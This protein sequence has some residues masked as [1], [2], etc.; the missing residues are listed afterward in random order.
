MPVFRRA[1]WSRRPR[2]SIASKVKARAAIDGVQQT[3][4]RG[5][6]QT[7]GQLLLPIDA[8]GVDLAIEARTDQAAG[9]QEA[10]EAAQLGDRV[11]ERSAAQSLPDATDERF[12][13]RRGER[14]Q[15]LRSE[16][17]VEMGEELS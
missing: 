17:I 1:T 7:A 3:S 16:L 11:L 6:R 4:D 10:Q 13:I 15:A 2:Q 14:G 12:D 8:W 5:P 9:R